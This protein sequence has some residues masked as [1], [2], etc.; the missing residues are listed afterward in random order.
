MRRPSLLF[1]LFVDSSILENERIAFNAGSLTN[2][3]IMN[4]QDYLHVAHPAV[5]SFSK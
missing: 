4:V 5:L 3:I 1:D 2:S